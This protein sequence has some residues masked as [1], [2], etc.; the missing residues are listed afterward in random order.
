M[1]DLALVAFFVLSGLY[2]RMEPITVGLA[3]L[4]VMATVLIASLFATVVSSGILIR[5]QPSGK[6]A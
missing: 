6:L 4:E 3:M 2:G 5:V 1:A